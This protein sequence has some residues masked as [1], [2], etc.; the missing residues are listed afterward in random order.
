MI[1]CTVWIM[2][3]TVRYILLQCLKLINLGLL[4]MLHFKC[5]GKSSGTRAST[6]TF[7]GT[8]KQRG[9]DCTRDLHRDTQ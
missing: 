6:K 2:K 3:E 9:Q 4:Q 8:P 7:G 1:C 5:N